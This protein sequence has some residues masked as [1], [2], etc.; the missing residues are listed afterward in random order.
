MTLALKKNAFVVC[1]LSLDDTG[2][3]E[4]LVPRFG[5]RIGFGLPGGLFVSHT[6]TKYLIFYIKRI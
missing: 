1:D 3:Y 5:Y 6:I 2:F 4:H